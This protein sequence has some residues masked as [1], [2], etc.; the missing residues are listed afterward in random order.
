MSS[1]DKLTRLFGGCF[2][3]GLF[4]G[5]GIILIILLVILL[6]G[7]DLLDFIF[8]EDNALIWIILIILVI[9]NLDF[10][11]GCGCC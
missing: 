9:S 6:L 5:G 11:G 8:C 3:D 1:Q 10:D 2:G 7:D 4:G